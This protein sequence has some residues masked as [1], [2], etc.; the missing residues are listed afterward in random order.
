MLLKPKHGAVL[1]LLSLFMI[2][3][4]NA[5]ASNVSHYCFPYDNSVKP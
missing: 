1:L 5:D 3:A 4:V 2:I